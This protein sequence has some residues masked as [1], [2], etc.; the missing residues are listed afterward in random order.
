MRP[1]YD[2]W[3]LE[4]IRQATNAGV[5][6]DSITFDDILRYLYFTNEKPGNA[7]KRYIDTRIRLNAIN[8]A[9]F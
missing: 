9:S 6:I 1:I 4:V 8:E 7:V 3:L 2:A 5:S